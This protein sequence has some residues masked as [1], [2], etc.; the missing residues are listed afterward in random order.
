MQ[1][2]RAKRVLTMDPD[3]PV[4]DDAE[5]VV[6]GG[7]I[8]AV[9]PWTAVRDCGPATDLGAVTVA[10]GLINAHA[11]LGLS[12]LAGRIPAGLGFAGWAD[13]LFACLREKP[14]ANAVFAAV[15]DMADQG[16]AFVVDVVGPGGEDIRSALEDVGVGGLLLREMAGRMRGERVVPKPLPGPWSVAVHALYSTDPDLARCLKAWAR[17]RNL[18]FSLHL[19]E[20]RG[21]NELLQTGSGDFADFLRQRRILPKGFRP[22]GLSAVGQAHALDLLDAATL[23]VHCVQISEDDIGLLADSG[24]TVCLCPRSNRWIGGGDPPAMELVA[25]G[26]P[27]CLG[28]DSLA[29][30]P[31]LNMWDELRCL[32]ELAPSLSL[33]DLLACATTVPARV[34]GIGSE[35]GSLTPG[36]RAVWA[37][38]PADFPDPAFR[39]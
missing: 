6:D 7:R 12:H 38:V 32:R 4:V 20:V 1:V 23:A 33:T 9:R 11:H 15:R 29:S 3:N 16:T 25:A 14:D 24:A 18:P 31:S 39:D 17:D 8:A 30:A 5:I 19:A 13:R 2:F 22:C 27:V 10:P 36:S 28:T 21:E 35:F 34:L 26:V 37:V